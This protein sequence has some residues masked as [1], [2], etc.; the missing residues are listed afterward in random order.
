MIKSSN[1]ELMVV[2]LIVAI[3]IDFCVLYGMKPYF[4]TKPWQVIGIILLLLKIIV[5]FSIIYAYIYLEN[6]NVFDGIQ[7][8]TGVGVSLELIHYSAMTFMTGSTVIVPATLLL[9]LLSTLES[10]LFVVIFS[11]FFVNGIK[12]GD[13]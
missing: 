8:T 9:K 1:S 6:P 12:K 4:L 11:Y 3:V 2:I 10:F 5:W 13:S 7:S